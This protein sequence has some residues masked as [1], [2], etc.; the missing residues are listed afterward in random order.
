MSMEMDAERTADSERGT[1]WMAAAEGENTRVEQEK[2][3]AIRPWVMRKT[4]AGASSVRRT[5]LHW[6]SGWGAGEAPWTL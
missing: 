1:P 4:G 2:S 5:A 6:I 3:R